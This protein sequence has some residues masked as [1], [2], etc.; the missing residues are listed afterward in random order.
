MGYLW[1][2]SRKAATV[3]NIPPDGLS[4]ER[5]RVDHLRH[6]VNNPLSIIRGHSQLMRRRLERPDA[7][8]EQS[9]PVMLVHVTAIDAAVLRVMM[10]MDGFARAEGTPEKPRPAASDMQDQ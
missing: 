8:N 1:P 3:S 6:E 2:G 10:A 7:L 9:L 5:E 4:S